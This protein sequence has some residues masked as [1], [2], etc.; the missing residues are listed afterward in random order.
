VKT[1]WY[2][3]GYTQPH[4]F[5]RLMPDGSMGLVI[6]L[7]ENSVRIYDSRNLTKFS[8]LDGAIFLGAQTEFFVIDT[9]E[10]RNVIGA[11]FAAGGA[12]PFLAAPAGELE[13]LHVSVGDL[14]R[15]EHRRI[16][17]RLLEIP[18][19]MER[20]RQF[21][22]ELL[23]VAA[24][25]MEI[26]SDVAYAAG[27]LDDPARS[28]ADVAACSGLSSR[29]LTQ[30]FRDAVGLTPKA[31]SRVRRFQRAL[32]EMQSPEAADWAQIALECGYYDQSHFNNDFREFSGI[33]PS[34]YVAVKT[35]HLNHVPLG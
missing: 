24:G 20:C 15:A 18:E 12:F 8:R 11:Q 22:R 21:E 10:Q 28:V 7:D 29:R 3:E 27:A 5:E 1:I 35:P 19:A 13:G 17:E 32:R 2:Y 31:Y 26:R 9:A 30:V 6:N 4:S 25:R 34:E 14:W 33:V 16:R 23:A